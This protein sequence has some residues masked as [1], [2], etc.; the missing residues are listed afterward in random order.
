[1]IEVMPLPA[2]NDG[3][4]APFWQ[5][6]LRSQLVIQ[7]CARCARLR[8]PP[9]PMCPYCRSCEH[10][11][12]VMSGNAR[13]WSFATPRAPLLPVFEALTPYVVAIAELDED[14]LLRV[15]G[16]LL[17]ADGSSVKGVDVAGVRIGARVRV[18]FKTY[19]ADVAL[20]CW[21]AV[22][23]INDGFARSE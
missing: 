10:D 8:F 13:I 17:A 16:N 5:A 3:A 18:R 14:P 15:I 2:T 6:A 21:L 12:E 11:W 22:Q 7:K 19:A 9:R 20:P 23:E 1:M 4:D